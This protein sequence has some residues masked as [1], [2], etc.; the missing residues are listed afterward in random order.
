MTD[1]LFARIATAVAGL[2]LSFGALAAAGG[3]VEQAG[4]DIGDRASL[5]PPIRDVRAIGDE[6]SH[7]PDA[8]KWV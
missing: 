6:T 2:V 5:Q 3:P 8:T 4:T 1:R 7:A